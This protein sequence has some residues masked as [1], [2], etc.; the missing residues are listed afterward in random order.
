MNTFQ[1]IVALGKTNETSAS[2]TYSDGVTLFTFAS[3]PFVVGDF[4]FI[5]NSGDTLVSYVSEVLATTGTTIT[6]KAPLSGGFSSAS[7]LMWTP[8]SSFR[9]E[10]GAATWAPARD[11]DYGITSRETITGGITQTRIRSVSDRV[12]LNF[13]KFRVTEI[14]E[15]DGLLSAASGGLSQVS[16]AYFDPAND[17]AQVS[18]SSMIMPPSVINY[19]SF[20]VISSL[21]IDFKVA[22][23]NEGIYI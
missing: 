13:D 8:T 3:H 12:R 18:V 21:S 2:G 1:P 6:T 10:W 15:W 19:E 23:G 22:N 7:V 14:A 5:R 20:G 17:Q 11:R 9:P 16:I 4:M